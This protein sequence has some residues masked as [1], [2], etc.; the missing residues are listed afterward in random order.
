MGEE[1]RLT[2]TM[3]S[4]KLLVLGFVRNYI[5]AHHAS[6]S[7]GE[8]E[9]GTGIMRQQVWR[10]VRKLVQEGK[11]TKARGERGLG[12]PDRIS[13]AVQLLIA[14]GFTVDA[15]IERIRLPGVT[16]REI[17]ASPPTPHMQRE[18]AGDDRA[19]GNGGSS[20]PGARSAA[21]G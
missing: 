1:Y 9:A 13:E 7:Y 3:V 6:P 2:S 18:D 21:D 15:D 14:A 4:S 5:T 11:L 17:P 10:I 20:L 12:L 16:I 19:N 8:I